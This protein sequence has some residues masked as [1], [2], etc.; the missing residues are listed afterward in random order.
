MKRFFF[1]AI[2]FFTITT[3]PCR[4]QNKYDR[5]WI[6]GDS[7]G[8]DFNDLD[9]PSPVLSHCKNIVEPVASISDSLGSLQFY[10]S[11]YDSPPQPFF[12]F[13]LNAMKIL[14]KNGN[15]FCNGD[16]IVTAYTT[17]QGSL[18]IPAPSKHGIYYLFNV[19]CL[20]DIKE[21]TPPYQSG[22]RYSII[23]MNL[24]NGIGCVTEKNILLI[25]T[26]MTEKLYAVKHAN[27][28]DWWIV[29]H[30]AGNSNTFLKYL[31]TANG[32]EGPFRQ[33]VGTIIDDWDLSEGQMKFSQDGTKMAYVDVE[34][35]FEIYEFDR[36]TGE[37]NIVA[38][39]SSYTMYPSYFGYYG[40][41][42]S[43]NGE[44]LYITPYPTTSYIDGIIS[45]FYLGS[46]DIW[47]TKQTVLTYVQ[48]ND[49]FPKLLGQLQLGPN[50]KIYCAMGSIWPLLYSGQYIYYLISINNPNEEGLLCNAQLNGFNLLGSSTA[51][52]PNMPNYNLGPIIPPT[53]DAGLGTETCADQPLQLQAVSCSTCIYD[54]QPAEYL[55][56]ANIANPI[57]TVNATTTFTLMVTDT[58]IH[59]SCNKTSTDTVTVFVTDNTPTIQTLYVIPAGDE[60]F[61]LQDLQPNTS[62][63]IIS[64]NGQRVYQTENYQNDLELKNLSAGMYYYKMNLPG[65]YK[66]EGKFVVVR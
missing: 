51:G 21:N 33:N 57:A 48:E 53:V 29:S 1:L 56:S 66:L 40:C 37:L 43:P 36:C 15:T 41:E 44:Y 26:L 9:A 12:I 17:T 28:K 58:S 65:C 13:H 59:A 30:K 61:F 45:Q 60:F 20:Y 64:V 24:N 8:I 18:I 5:V 19:Q 23:D 62:L 31:L 10:I 63:E 27:G 4:A 55:S 32:I 47:S 11:G 49:T 50:G 38:D 14:D 52:L 34:G 16:S 25:D 39:L 42:F 2:L 3:L 22:L 7:A 6:F 46:S 54:W 35:N